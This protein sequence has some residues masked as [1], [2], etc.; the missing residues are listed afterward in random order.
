MDMAIFTK[1][2]KLT[3]G[4]VLCG[5]LALVGFFLQIALG[6]FEWGTLRFPVNVVLLACLLVFL[7]LAFFLRKKVAFFDW[8]GSSAAAVPAISFA[9]LLAVVM[10]LTAQIPERGWLGSM[11]TFWPFVLCYAFLVIVVGMLALDRAVRLFRSWREIPSFLL[12]LGFFV[13]VVCAS[14]GNPDKKDLEM[15]LHEGETLSKAVDAAGISY[16]TGVSIKL[17]DF[18]METYPNGMPKRFASDVVVT[19]KSGKETSAVIEVNKPLKVDGWKMYQYG[20]DEEAGTES[21]IS[22]L[23]L[24]RDPWLPFVYSG[25]FMMLS[26][27][28]LM[29]FTGFNRKEETL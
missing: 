9:L 5:A 23:E 7:S 17:D 26:G 16:D 21:K 18:T 27:A 12:H 15:T 14:L 4:F 6:P 13:T 3:V 10:G 19:G 28:F 2:W 11:T 29:I 22:V 20:Y 8:L 25:I 24:V 1:P